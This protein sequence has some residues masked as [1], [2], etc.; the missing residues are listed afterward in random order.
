MTAGADR[1][2]ERDRII[3]RV[4]EQ[5]RDALFRPQPERAQR[6]GEAERARLQF[7]VGQRAVGIDE[8]E[9]AAEPARDIGVDEIG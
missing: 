7:A 2:P 9:L 6:V 1:A 4:V 3:D 5:Q 8:G